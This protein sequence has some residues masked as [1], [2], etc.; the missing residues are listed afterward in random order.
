M[1]RP[2]IFVEGDH[3][4]SDAGVGK[5]GGSRPRKSP[6]TNSTIHITFE[7]NRMSARAGGAYASPGWQLATRKPFDEALAVL[8]GRGS[9]GRGRAGRSTR[10]S[11]PA[12]RWRCRGGVT[13]TAPG[14]PDQ[15]FPSG[16]L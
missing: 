16:D 15:S 13:C 1:A 10:R 12:T 3:V 11:T 8:V 6:V 2:K 9:S 7:E 5:V 4:K 14:L